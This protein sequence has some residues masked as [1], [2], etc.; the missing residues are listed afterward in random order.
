MS[1]P[2]DNFDD[3]EPF[4][5]EEL[6]ESQTEASN[7]RTFLMVAGILGGI[8]VL[9]LIFI[10]LYAVFLGPR[11]QAARQT[12]SADAI[13]KATAMEFSIQETERAAKATATKPPLA[14][15]TR[16]PAVSAATNTPVIALAAT[17]TPSG[18]QATPNLTLTVEAL[19]TQGAN[20]AK[21]QVATSTALPT[22]G[23]AEDIGLPGLLGLAAVLI[24]IIFLA[25]RLRT[26][27]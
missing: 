10:G 25:R 5:E 6:A 3:N 17:S 9:I 7:N 16:A 23:F 8:T 1:L 27:A 26:A 13:T 21:T 18:G 4:D 20:A 12:E 24:I 19:I 15:A 14:T 22:T 11:N 2:F